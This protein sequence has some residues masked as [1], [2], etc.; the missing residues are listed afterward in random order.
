MGLGL[1]I[2]RKSRGSRTRRVAMHAPALKA[3]Q[4]KAQ[5][6]RSAA[7]GTGTKMT[8]SPVGA[9]ADGEELPL[10]LTGLAG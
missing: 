10:A 6:K 8:A 2:T 7:L 5:G 1:I 3:R 9:P 4:S